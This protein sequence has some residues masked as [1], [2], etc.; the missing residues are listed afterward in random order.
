M[1][2]ARVASRGL[3]VQLNIEERMGRGRRPSAKVRM[4]FLSNP[5][6]EAAVETGGAQARD[7]RR[8]VARE[9]NIIKNI[10]EIGNRCVVFTTARMAS[11]KIPIALPSLFRLSTQA[12]GGA[13]DI[14]EEVPLLINTAELIGV[15]RLAL[16]LSEDE[17]QA[18]RS[19][20]V[21]LS[22]ARKTAVVNSREFCFTVRDL[23]TFYF[24]R[25]FDNQWLAAGWIDTLEVPSN[26]DELY[27][28]VNRII[29]FFTA[30]PAKENTALGVTAAHAQTLATAMQSSDNAYLAGEVASMTKRDIRNAKATA[31]RKRLSGLC[32]EL[33]QRFEDLDPRWRRFGFNLPGAPTV[34]EVPQEV[35]ASAIS[36]ARLQISCDPSVGATSYRFYVQRPI[37]DPV[38]T[39]VGT[40]TEPLLITDPLVAGQE[41][42]VYV[43][44][45]NDGAES[46]LST[47]VTV[48]AVAAAAA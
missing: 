48:T 28:L 20:L 39:P 10:P 14:G 47:A 42:L 19:S 5:F 36:G 37:L 8:P 45:T 29:N 30:N 13:E 35:I 43:S 18:A 22:T 38:P 15:D 40:S 21:V 11:N 7:V 27:M 4:G 16:I 1:T 3:S 46:Q 33:S 32:K 23:L 44:A 12:F 24:G 41:Y 25:H 2:P 17:Y 34:P 9:S 26:Y 6:P 31:M